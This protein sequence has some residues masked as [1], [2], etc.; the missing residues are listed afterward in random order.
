MKQNINEE[1]IPITDK[2]ELEKETKCIIDP[3]NHN[4]IN[5]IK[6]TLFLVYIHNKIIISWTM[7]EI[8]SA[9]YHK[10]YRFSY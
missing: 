5:F 3:A 8:S 7:V 9:Q 10:K 6:Q 1:I 4:I 2:L